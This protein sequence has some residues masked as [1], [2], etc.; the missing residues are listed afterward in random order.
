MRAVLFPFTILFSF[1]TLAQGT[2]CDPQGNVAI[3]SNYDGGALTINVD[4]DIPDLHIGIV[5]YE[6]AVI[7]ITGPYVSNVVAVQW[8][9]YNG[10]NDH[11]GTGAIT[12]STVIG[13]VTSGISDVVVMPPST[14]ANTNGYPLI[15]CSYNCD[16]STQQGGCNTVDQ[17]ADYFLDAWGGNLLFHL[18]QYGCWG[19]VYDISDGGNCC[20]GQLP[21][22]VEDRGAIGRWSVHP[23]PASDVLMSDR[24]GRF[25][26]LDVNGRLVKRITAV[27]TAIPVSDLAPGSYQL[28]SAEDGQSRRFI[29]HR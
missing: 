6:F 24:P 10:N 5:S 17:V 26:V 12:Q 29:V 8:A 25:D 21:T 9:G 16:I 15:I 3:F 18:T 20:V 11:C 22:G 27:S 7:S 14:L 2:F 1:A 4:Q 23:V 13:G 19:G 28:R